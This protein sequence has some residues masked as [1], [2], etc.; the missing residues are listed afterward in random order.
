MLAHC[1]CYASVACNKRAWW[2]G[3]SFASHKGTEAFHVHT[4]LDDALEV[5]RS[6]H[7]PMG[8]TREERMAL[9][10]VYYVEAVGHHMTSHL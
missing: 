9:S 8:F 10:T 1:D 5:W 7:Q 3:W 6:S 4:P 2:P